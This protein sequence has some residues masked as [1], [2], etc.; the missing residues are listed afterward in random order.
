MSE[1]NF[2]TK[3]GKSSIHCPECYGHCMT[4]GFVLSCIECPFETD[5]ESPTGRRLIRE[6]IRN[7][8]SY[9]SK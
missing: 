9:S 5:S 7:N 4:D 3:W 1:S 6:N 8:E 2:D